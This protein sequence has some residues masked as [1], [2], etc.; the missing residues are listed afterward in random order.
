MSNPKEAVPGDLIIDA[1]DIQD[2][3]DVTAEEIS[4][5]VKFH[6]G[7]EKAL[8]NLE[9]LKPDDI[10]RAGINPKAVQDAVALIAQHRHC[11]KLLPAAEKLAEL[12]YETKMERA[13]RISLLIGEIVSQAKRRGQGSAEAGLVL[14]PLKDLLDYQLGPANKAVVTRK[15]KG[16]EQEAGDSDKE[17]ASGGAG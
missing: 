8:A 1:S 12:I 2:V 9:R 11:E 13:H 5:F 6:D 15:K 17:P 14:G 7:Y 16:K 4:G 3:V 10:D